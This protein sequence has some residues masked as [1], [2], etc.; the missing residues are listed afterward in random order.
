MEINELAGI[1]YAIATVMFA[2]LAVLMLTLW[3]DR[4]K[5]GFVALAAAGF[6]LTWPLPAICI[7]ARRYGAGSPP[8]W[9]GCV[10]GVP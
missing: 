5:A 10:L 2:G 7:G 3:R 4:P 1:G 6:A 9:R 8:A